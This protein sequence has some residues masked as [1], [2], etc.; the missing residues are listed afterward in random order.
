MSDATVLFNDSLIAGL[1]VGKDYID[2]TVNQFQ[3]EIRDYIRQY[4]GDRPAP[5]VDGWIVLIGDDGIATGYTVM[6]FADSIL[7]KDP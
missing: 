3:S 6:A 4:R 2:R 7:E 5:E 1:R